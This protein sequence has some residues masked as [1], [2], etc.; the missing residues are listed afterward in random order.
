MPVSDLVFA[1]LPA[2]ENCLAAA[3]R[4]EVHEAL[5]EILHLE[6]EL[7]DLVDRTGERTRL[8]VDL[9]GRI[10]ELGGRDPA[11]VAADPSFELLLPLERLDVRAPAGGPLLR[12]RAPPLGRLA[13][14]ARAGAHPL[15]ERPPLPERGVRLLGGEV[16]HECTPMR[17]W[18][19]LA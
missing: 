3:Q 12:Q 18:R 1:Q 16:A 6:P 5:V 4:G 17:R 7:D 15:D 19:P 13:G 8:A 14:P 2:E 10:G 9:G 11:A